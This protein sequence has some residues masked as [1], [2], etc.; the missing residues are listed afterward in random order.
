MTLLT[1]AVVAGAH[2][3][4]SPR[5]SKTYLQRLTASMRFTEACRRTSSSITTLSADHREFDLLAFVYGY[6][7]E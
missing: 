4:R 3:R 6:P 1:R 7:G 2:C 5:V